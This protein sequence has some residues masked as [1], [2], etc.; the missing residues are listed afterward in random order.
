MT[1]S[2]NSVTLPD[3]RTYL[4]TNAQ[5]RAALEVPQ[6]AVLDPQYLGEGEHN[7]NFQFRHPATGERFVL[8]INTIPQ[9][10]HSNQVRYEFSALELLEPCGRA[11]KPLYLDDSSEAPGE[12]VMV[13]GFCEGDEL[14]FDRLRPGDLLCATQLM[15]DIHAV[16]LPENAADALFCPA[17]PMR[18]LFD[19]CLARFR[20]YRAS[21]VEDARLTRWT[22]RFIEH[23]QQALDTPRDP[24][25]CTHIVNTETLSSHFLIPEASARAAA[26]GAPGWRARPG[27]FID[28]ER[29]VIGEVAQD[30]A[31]F[32]APTTTFW[33]SDFL[34]SVDEAA[35]VVE[36]Y[37]CA[38]DGRFP[39]GGFDGRFRAWLMMTALRS[40]TWFCKA[41]PDYLAGGAGRITEKTMRKF[42]VYLSDGFME[43]IAKDCFGL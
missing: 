31:Y 16:R 19:E 7:R 14:D 32:V 28:W 26:E 37:W 11:P 2:Q 15:A 13:I 10:F 24:R 39:R 1:H 33:D 22:E 12:G 29:P 42:P 41:L 43:M 35:E 38:V 34:F 8:R 40:T 25:D 18:A 3:A 9:P 5:L 30:L 4:A 36:Q 23:A 21:G 20:T 27:F 6:G 17:D